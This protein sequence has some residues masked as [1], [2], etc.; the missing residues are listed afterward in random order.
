MTAQ[1]EG[2]KLDSIKWILVVVLVAVGV[3]GNYHFAAESLLYRVIGLVVLAGF[4][5]FL[6]LQTQKGK[7]FS[8]LLKEAKIEIRKVVWPTP[9]ELR[10]TTIIVVVF[11]LIVALVLWGLDSLVSWIV[12]GF[13]G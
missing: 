13:I 12:A 6:S 5:V 10:Q 1:I 8:V 4:A 2:G 9:Q 7:A 3:V 11:V